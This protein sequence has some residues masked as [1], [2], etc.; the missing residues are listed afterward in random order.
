NYLK[1]EKPTTRL[2]LTKRIY[3]TYLKP[4]SPLEVNVTRSQVKAVELSISKSP[5]NLDEKLF[6][7]VLEE[8]YVNLSDTIT[9]FRKTP[10]YKNYLQNMKQV[11]KLMRKTG[12]D[13][14]KVIT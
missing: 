10:E 9:R 12:I 7:K 1:A 8:I 14:E 2:E 6:N 4:N 13:L 11:N 3:E 5:D